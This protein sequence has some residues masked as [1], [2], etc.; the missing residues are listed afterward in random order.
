MIRPF[1]TTATIVQ[2]NTLSPHVYE[3]VCTIANGELQYMPGQYVTVL[4]D[5]QTRRQYSFATPNT[6][7]K[8]FSI[9]IDVS[10]MGPGSKFFLE[11]NVGDAISILAPLG[12]FH[13][14]P[15]TQPTVFIATGTG[16][17]PFRTMIED[18]LTGGGKQDIYLYWGLRFEED[19]FWKDLFDGWVKTYS[20]FHY[21]IVLSKPTHTWNGK[22]G[23]VTEHVQEE[24]PSLS[25]HSFYLCGNRHMISDVK[26]NLLAR[27][28]SE[29]QIKTELF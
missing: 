3:F 18:Y 7:K 9:V 15:P 12:A 20:I 23:H 4:I 22:S 28:V 14:T 27:S 2:K 29:E 25:T 21:S 13:F 6:N 5:P 1:Q 24:I 11:R 10:P 17:V 26:T 16:I 8:Q 19:I